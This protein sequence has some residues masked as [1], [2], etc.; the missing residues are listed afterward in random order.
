[1]AFTSTSPISGSVWDGPGTTC[2]I[3]SPSNWQTQVL[4][5]LTVLAN[6]NHSGSAGEGI[7]IIAGS[8]FP[9]IDDDIFSGFFPV[10]STNWDFKGASILPYSG[11]ISSS[12]DGASIS[13]DLY[14]RSGVYTINSYHIQQG[15]ASRYGAT[16]VCIDSTLTG[17]VGQ[18][19]HA[20]GG[21]GPSV[22]GG[23]TYGK[24]AVPISASIATGA[25]ERR[26]ILVSASSFTASGTQGYGGGISVI[27]IHRTADVD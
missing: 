17:C 18:F 24:L 13:Y 6:H 21:T 9:T 22:A 27:S 7:E 19:D 10:A 25:G 23:E 11:M 4:D 3:I 16:K 26:L 15:E 1:M 12:I 8:F 5:N 20:N 2:P 14:L